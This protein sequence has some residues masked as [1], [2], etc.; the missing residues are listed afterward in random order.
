MFYFAGVNMPNQKENQKQWHILEQLSK[1]LLA[2]AAHSLEISHLG[3]GTE[4]KFEA[5]K[6]TGQ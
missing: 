3:P 5:K 6:K 2:I 4:F 1:T